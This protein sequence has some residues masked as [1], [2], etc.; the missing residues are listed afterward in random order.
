MS[1]IH[2]EAIALIKK[3]LEDKFHRKAEPKPWR[4]NGAL[5]DITFRDI[6][7]KMIVVEVGHI[8]EHSIPKYLKS[9]S[10]KR[11]LWYSKTGELVGKWV[12]KKFGEYF[13]GDYPTKFTKE[14]IE[15]M[16]EE[17]T[18]PRDFERLY[19]QCPICGLHRNFFEIRHERYSSGYRIICEGCFEMR[20]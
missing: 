4:V 17:E 19:F 13:S 5:P 1:K 9:P 14:L 2:D 6:H 15:K 11:I 7:G 3:K 8:R 10:I 16:E 18:R 20:K 12:P